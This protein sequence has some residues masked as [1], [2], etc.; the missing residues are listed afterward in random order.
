[1]FFTILHIPLII[2]QCILF[3]A[4]SVIAMKLMSFTNFL[5][6]DMK[7]KIIVNIMLPPLSSNIKLKTYKVLVKYLFFVL[8]YL[9]DF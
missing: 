4:E 5:K 9:V 8:K 2:L 7:R 6:A 3:L 1:M